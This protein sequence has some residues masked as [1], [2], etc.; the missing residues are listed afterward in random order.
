MVQWHD[1]CFISL[2][3][4]SFVLASLL[5]V[6]ACYGGERHDSGV[7]P[8]G[9]TCSDLTPRGL[10][11]VGATFA[12]TA[13]IVGPSPTAIGGTQDIAIEYDRAVSGVSVPLDLAYTADDDG[14]NGVAL[15][16]QAGALVTMRG[17]ASRTNYLRISDAVTGELFD[18]HSLTGAAI[19][20]IAFVP[21]TTEL[22]PEGVD[23]A[24]ATGTVKAG[25]ALYGQVQA[26]TGPQEE[27]L[28]D[29]SMALELAGATQLAWD[30]LQLASA[31][32]GTYAL[33]VTAGDRPTTNLDVIVVDHLDQIVKA[34]ENATTIAPM[35]SAIVCF[36]AITDGRYVAGLAWHYLVDS[37]DKTQNA[38]G[39]CISVGT[40]QTSGTVTVVGS[41]MGQSATLTLTIA[42]AR[43]VMPA[44]LAR[45]SRAQRVFVPTAGDRASM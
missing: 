33:G 2:H 40:N 7:C 3:M 30:S 43:T 12:D 10:E 27:R 9:E 13:S 32:T 28:I 15:E 8:A 31:T 18:R 42:A 11:F 41:A 4:K 16:H 19:S 1:Q 25:V 24:F 37:V 44:A 45:Q 36:D 29:Q 38:L 26:S 23:L 35:G 17:I 14:G 34:P 5:L 21:A 6:P 39:N 20:R 22:V